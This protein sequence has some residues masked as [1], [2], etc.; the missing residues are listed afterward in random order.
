MP[1]P[2]KPRYTKVDL[3]LEV[4]SI[5]TLLIYLIFTFYIW[6]DVPQSIPDHFGW[7]GM[8]DSWGTKGVLPTMI[9]VTG[10]IFILLSIISR[11]P[12]AIN[13]PIA[14]KKDNSKSYL[15][16]IFSLILWLKAEL[17]L[18]TSYI[19]IQGIR[20]ALNQSEGLGSYF[21]LILLLVLFGTSTFFIYQVNN[22]K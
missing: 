1:V 7:T 18:F 6:P 3:I 10:F 20:V 14:M 9:Y 8:P 19:G 16:L 17:V 12:T 15:Q 21:T 13:F 4:I 2:G 11:F 22:L 5:A